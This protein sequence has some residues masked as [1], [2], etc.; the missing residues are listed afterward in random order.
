VKY[1]IIGTAGHVDHGKSALI[2]ALTGT[3]TD[4]LKEEKERGISIDLGFASLALSGEILAGIVDVPGHERFLKNMLAGT[5]G[6]DLA[7]LTIAADEGVMPQTREH[8]AMLQLFGVKH[9]LVVINKMDK[10]DSEWLELMEEEIKIFLNGTFLEQAPVCRV[11]AVTGDGVSG[12][13]E[14][15]GQIAA[16]IPARDTKAP[17]RLWIDRTFSIKGHGVIITGSVLSGTA[18]T[19]DSLVLYP[20]GQVVKIRGLE[21]HGVKTE[22]IRA[23][24]R[25]AINL[26]G[27]ELGNIGR[28]M[29]LSTAER[30]QVNSVWDVQV[31]WRQE[32][33]G[34]SRVRLHI[35]T[36][37]FIGRLY[38]PKHSPD[39][40]YRLALEAALGAGAGDR[41]ILRLYSPQ[42]LLGGV[43]LLGA[44]QGKAK[45]YPDRRPLSAGVAN[46][47]GLKVVDTIVKW[48]TS[49]VPMEKIRRLAG[50][51][52]DPC[53]EDGLRK[54]VASGKILRLDKY[55]IG[56]AKL[57]DIATKISQMLAEYH[58]AQPNRFGMPKEEIRQKLALGEKEFEIL[59]VHFSIE[60][61]LILQGAD[62]ALPQHAAKH[63]GWRRN[64]AAEVEGV[65][66]GCG[67]I[68]IDAGFLAQK[69]NMTPG[70]AQKMLETLIKE[71]VVLRLGE[72]HVYRK[73]I[74]YIVD[75][76]Q[77][78]FRTSTT[79]SVAELRDL[80]NTSRKFALPVLEYMDMN[81][82]TIREGDVRR[83]GPKIKDLSEK[84]IF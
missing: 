57:Q 55:Y 68:D 72:I 81:K 1:L 31:E 32:V 12:L 71:G 60:Q 77:R 74:Q 82:Y 63:E 51:L 44:A 28:G 52:P 5:G 3:D 26:T 70:T 22:L 24:Q 29:A 4:R 39:G 30:G 21:T 54:L 2:K 9:G 79:L 58:Q 6:I 16:Q 11:S 34:G 49:P 59:L 84:T 35:G 75:V 13:K 8:L 78:H 83:V 41:G 33:E 23:G 42:Y 67:L 64:F 40:Q 65:L 7:M 36:G 50:Y 14:T 27:V 15:L 80:L 61:Q 37:E 53:I 73:T 62:M 48:Q 47:D 66:D 43:V 76:I 46:Q 18:R 69:L 19:G 38:K 10:V 25:A 20:A 45:E 56:A 17:F